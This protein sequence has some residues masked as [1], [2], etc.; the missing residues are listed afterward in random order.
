MAICET[1]VAIKEHPLS[2]KGLV[3]RAGGGVGGGGCGVTRKNFGRGCAAG[4]LNTSP[5]HIISRLTKYTHSYNLHVKRYP[6]HIIV[7]Y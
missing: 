4:T 2:R 5:I 7:E 1:V 6:I 3:E